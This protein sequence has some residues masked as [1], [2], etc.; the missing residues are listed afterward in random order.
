MPRASSRSSAVASAQLVDGRIE[1]LA[2]SV[3][4]ESIFA[5]AMPSSSAERHEPLLRPV[6]EVALQPPARLVARLDD[7]RARV[8]Q[9][10]LGLQAVRD[11]PEV[12]RETGGR[13]ARSA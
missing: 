2:A 12:P 5:R 11:V 13:E 1:E 10:A 7:A 8:A 3:G 6:V 9:L 4:L